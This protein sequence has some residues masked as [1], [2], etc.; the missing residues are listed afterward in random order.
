MAAFIGRRCGLK[1]IIRLVVLTLLLVG[2]SLAALSLHVVR[3]PG[4]ITIVPKNRLS[5]FGCYVDTTKW[6]LDDVSK[7][8]EVAT[9]LMQTN[10]ADTLA[11]TTTAATAA[12]RLNLLEKAIAAGAATPGSLRSYASKLPDVKF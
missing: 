4:A 3:S 5:V 6:T 8:A 12:E 9:R 11:H 10:H 7:N 2:W 1:T